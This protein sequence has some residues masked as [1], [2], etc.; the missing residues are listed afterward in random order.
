MHEGDGDSLLEGDDDKK[1]PLFRKDMSETEIMEFVVDSFAVAG[2]AQVTPANLRPLQFGD[3]PGF[4]FEFTYD[5][6]S[7]LAMQALVVGMIEKERLYLIMYTGTREH[8]F[9][10]HVNDVEAMIGSIKML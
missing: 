1:L 6:E 9:A 3:H 5:T 8:Y 10:K 2:M 7:G 4:R